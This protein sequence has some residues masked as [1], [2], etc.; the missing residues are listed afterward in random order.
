MIYTSFVV[1]MMGLSLAKEIFKP[2]IIVFSALLLL[3]FGNII[4]I[5]EAF[6]GFSNKGMI[7]VGFLFVVS[8]ALQAS[9]LFENWVMRILGQNRSG[10]RMRYFRLLFPVAALSAFLNNTPIVASLIPMIKTWSKRNGIASS[11]F[12]I[13]L[14]Y[15][16]ILGGTCTL[17]G[18]STN[19][20]IHGML[21]ESG[22]EGFT[23]FEIT[24]VGLPVAFIAILFIV[25]FGKYLLPDRKEPIVQLG[26][27]T[28]EFVVEAKVSRDF[29]HLNQTVENAG[30]R[31]LQGLFLFQITRGGEIIAPVGREELI[32][33]GDRLFF[34]GLP[35]T[36]FELQK[37][38]GLDTIRD[39]EFDLKNLDSD[40]LGTYEAVVSNSSSLVGQTVRESEFRKRYS[41]VILAIHRSGSRINRKIGD[42]SF[43]PNDTLFILAK[44]GF[45]TEYYHT[46]DFS[47]VSSSLDIYEKPKWK[48]NLALLILIAMIA[49]AA[50]EIIPIIQAA[51]GAAVLMVITGILSPQDARK[52]VNVDVLLLIA[53]SFGIAKGLQN[54][55]LAEFLAT[56]LTQSLDVFGPV[57]VISGLYIASSVLTWIITNNAVA[58]MLFP[59]ALAI[60]NVSDLDIRPVMLTLALGASAS[61]VTPIGY[62]TNLMVYGPGGYQ[63]KD[64]VRIGLPLNVI[65]GVIA[66]IT[67]KLLYF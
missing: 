58:A 60:Q 38:V 41:A 61:F 13:P 34:T 40:R 56:H 18:T 42:I 64:F 65:V 36:I 10:F 4:T 67:L 3:L 31:H 7:A 23:F 44:R 22:F 51:A 28:R 46:R 45:D 24:K 39:A 14:S 15:A 52:S 66:I 30:L 53:S 33:V 1:I 25:F 21:I 8:A 29:A 59:V 49:V 62:Q 27:Q 32:Q 5:D 9:G 47:L 63:F 2:S 11:K 37:M 54:S 26:D 35:E 19:L 17:I 57:G 6:D 55:G 16:A 12:L 20:V 43:Q 48:G 50:L